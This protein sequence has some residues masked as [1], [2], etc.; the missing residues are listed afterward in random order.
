LPS[1]ALFIASSIFI[2]SAPPLQSTD[3]VVADAVPTKLRTKIVAIN[4]LLSLFH[5]PIFINLYITAGIHSIKLG[6]GGVSF[7]FKTPL[8]LSVAF[9]IL[10]FALYILPYQL[11]NPPIFVLILSPHKSQ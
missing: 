11:K 8:S 7:D 5:S 9:S 3:H 2:K 6:M 1:E 10:H 4:I